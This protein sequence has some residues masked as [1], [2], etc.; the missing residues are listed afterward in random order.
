MGGCATCRMVIELRPGFTHARKTKR[1]VP[2]EITERIGGSLATWPPAVC[3]SSS[4]LSFR[5]AAYVRF[6]VTRCPRREQ[7]LNV[8]SWQPP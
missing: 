7:F 6:T 5:A 1:P 3:G 2:F 8:R 4:A